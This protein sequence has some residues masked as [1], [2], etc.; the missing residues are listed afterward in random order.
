MT[1]RTPR[2]SSKR[3]RQA[4]PA[5]AQ[6]AAVAS[7]AK[8]ASSAPVRRSRGSAWLL[9]FLAVLGSTHAL[10]MVGAE[11][12][13]NHQI[14]RSIRQLAADVSELEA[15]VAGLEEVIEHGG[16]R[17]YLEQLARRQGYVY[18]DEILIVPIRQ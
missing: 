16:D 3:G 17:I 13:R 11:L 7:G 18:P 12:Y 14:T 9:T 15:E 2:I 5:S 8:S 6:T 10:V 4:S 1:V